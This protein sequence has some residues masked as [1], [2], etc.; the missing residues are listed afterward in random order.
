MLK[1]G[2]LFSQCG[3]VRKKHHLIWQCNDSDV[4][5]AVLTNMYKIV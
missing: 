1:N 4:L 3:F 5:M 2:K